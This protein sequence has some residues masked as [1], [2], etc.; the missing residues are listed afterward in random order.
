MKTIAITLACV[1]IAGTAFAAPE[2]VDEGP[3]TILG[4]AVDCSGAT[5]MTCAET[6]D[7]HVDATGGSVDTYGC[8]SLL[9]DGSTEAVYEICVAADTFLSVDMMY[10]HSAANDLD[11]FLLGS[12]DEAD[13]LVSSTGTSG[14]ENVSAAVTAGTYYV[15]VDGWDGLADGST[16]TV[17]VTCDAPCDPVSVDDTSWGDVKALY[18]E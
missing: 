5:A 4:R 13:C 1:L 15:V 16:H 2:K 8:T 17:S 3:H 12:C 9:Y 7:G 14:A 6:A 11:L 10:A 18:H